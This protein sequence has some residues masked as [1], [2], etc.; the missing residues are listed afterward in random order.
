MK[1]R[2]S[3]TVSSFLCSN[4]RALG[5]ALVFILVSGSHLAFGQE[6]YRQINLVSDQP[7]VALL[8]DTNLVNAWG[9]S[10]SSTSP[11]WVSDNGAGKATLYAVTNDAQGAPHVAKQGLE[12]M[13]P[14]EG[15]P[16][17][18]VFNDM[19]GFHGDI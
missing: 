12:V 5:A 11:F 9:I 6:T 1:I 13:I 8:Q 10:A 7:G 3:I 19:G 14:G 4:P 16:T 17:G 18:Q 2:R 15:N